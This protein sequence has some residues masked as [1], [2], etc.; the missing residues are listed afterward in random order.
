MHADD[1]VISIPYLTALD[2][3]ETDYPSPPYMSSSTAYKKETH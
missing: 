1:T 2:V 3:N